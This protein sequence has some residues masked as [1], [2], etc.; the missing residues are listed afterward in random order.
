M[1]KDRPSPDFLEVLPL[2]ALAIAWIIWVAVPAAKTVQTITGQQ[3]TGVA[4]WLD[5]VLIAGYFPFGLW[6]IK[7][8]LNRVRI[9][10]G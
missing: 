5:V 8:R 4:Y 7:P 10:E 1:R 6:G 2:F 3:T 9:V